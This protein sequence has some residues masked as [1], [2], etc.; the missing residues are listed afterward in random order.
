MRRRPVSA[1]K[2][3]LPDQR[4]IALEVGPLEVAQQPAAAAD[5]LQEP[6]AGVV[7]LGV[8][9]QMLGQVVYAFGQ[10]RDLDLGSAGVRLAVAEARDQLALAL[11]GD[12]HR[13]GTVAKRRQASRACATSRCI[14]STSASTLAN[15]RSP[16]S[17]VRNCSLS[18]LP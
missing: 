15:R 5:H 6:A 17:L 9:A 7:V 12:R 11:R 18:S 16:R 8:A 2:A 13:R 1:T 3:E 4:A 10:K 14:C